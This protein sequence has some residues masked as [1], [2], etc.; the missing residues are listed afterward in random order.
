MLIHFL[1]I[2][3]DCNLSNPLIY[4]FMSKMFKGELQQLRDKLTVAERTARS[5][6]QLKVSFFCTNEI[7]FNHRL[8]VYISSLGYL[9]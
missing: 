9:F 1:C 7:F 3:L 8:S 5:E 4:G 2:T 6:S